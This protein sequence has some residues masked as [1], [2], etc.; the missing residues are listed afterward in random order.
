MDSMLRIIPRR[1]PMG[2]RSLRIGFTLILH[3]VG[4]GRHLILFLSQGLKVDLWARHGLYAV[5]GGQH[6]AAQPGQLRSDHAALV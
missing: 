4:T 6:A 1:A 5:R 2:S 3:I